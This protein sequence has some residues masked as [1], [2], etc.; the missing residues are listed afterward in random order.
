MRA[1]DAHLAFSGSALLD[2]AYNLRVLRP[3]DLAPSS[4]EERRGVRIA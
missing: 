2:A 1:T 3:T 4:V